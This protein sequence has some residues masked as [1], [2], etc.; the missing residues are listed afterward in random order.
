MIAHIRF[1]LVLFAPCQDESN[2]DVRPLPGEWMRAVAWRSLARG[3]LSNGRHVRRDCLRA[4][5]ALHAPL[6]AL[7]RHDSAAAAQVRRVLYLAIGRDVEGVRS[8]EP[9]L[10]SFLLVESLGLGA[11]FTEAGCEDAESNICAD[12]STTGADQHGSAANAS[13]V[14]DDA[15]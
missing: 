2:G 14:N 13:S 9:K 6:R 3:C 10:A 12:A 4:A 5:C 15:A 1:A 8:M 7:W 11:A